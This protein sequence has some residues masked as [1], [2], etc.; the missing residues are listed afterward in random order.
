[1]RCPSLHPARSAPRP[2]PLCGQAHSAPPPRW[3]TTHPRH[4]ATRRPSACLDPPLRVAGAGCE[5]NGAAGAGEH[6]YATTVLTHAYAVAAADARTRT[7]TRTRTRSACP[8]APLVL[9]HQLWRGRVQLIRWRRCEQRL[10]RHEGNAAAIRS[11]LQSADEQ[12]RHHHDTLPNLGRVQNG[13]QMI[14]HVSCICVS[15]RRISCAALRVRAMAT[16]DT[17]AG[18][19]PTSLPLLAWRGD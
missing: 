5:E 4:A 10:E 19:Q 2:R 3:P 8:A 13:T 16:E 17:R 7:R 1:M 11:V 18:C 14:V 9:P 15:M 6:V 12:A